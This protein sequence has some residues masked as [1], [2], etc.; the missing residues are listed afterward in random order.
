MKKSLGIQAS[1]V[2]EGAI[3]TTWK[4]TTQV[5][6]QASTKSPAETVRDIHIQIQIHTICSAHI[7]TLMGA[8]GANPE[9]PGQAPSLSR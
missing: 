2:K 3:P 6:V 9:T 8:Q 1:K 5:P 7:S 4:L